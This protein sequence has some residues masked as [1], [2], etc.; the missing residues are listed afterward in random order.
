M[1][2]RAC[3]CAMTMSTIAT[4]ARAGVASTGSNSTAATRA[5]FK[6]VEAPIVLMMFA[7]GCLSVL[8]AIV[9]MMR[10]CRC[11]GKPAPVIAEVVDL[12]L[13]L[14]DQFQ[15]VFC[16][17]SKGGNSLA[18]KEGDTADAEPLERCAA[19]DLTGGGT[20]RASSM[21]GS[22]PNEFEVVAP[23][24]KAKVVRVPEASVAKWR[25]VFS[26]PEQAVGSVA[27]RE[28]ASPAV[29]AVHTIMP[30]AG[31]GEPTTDYKQTGMYKRIKQQQQQA[32]LAQASA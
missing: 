11:P 24:A 7:M 18:F 6:L 3:F 13:G 29:T 20:V 27:R 16:E 5:E 9:Y 31:G 25:S 8:A 10:T 14:R 23:G 28:A 21:P 12:K 1:T 30:G 19:I 32:R 4:S 15:A 22:P 2:S 26:M 17:V